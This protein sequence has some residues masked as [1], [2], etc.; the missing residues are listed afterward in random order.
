MNNMPDFTPWAGGSREA[1]IR[2]TKQMLD[3]SSFFQSQAEARRNVAMWKL[4]GELFSGRPLSIKD[5]E[6]VIGYCRFC[7]APYTRTTPGGGLGMC[8]SSSCHKKFARE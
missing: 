2:L 8:A 7:G 6:K 5:D 3:G 4:Q 1:S